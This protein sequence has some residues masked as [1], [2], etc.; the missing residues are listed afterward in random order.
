[1]FDFESQ[2]APQ[3]PFLPPQ[4]PFCRVSNS[5]C[6]V[7]EPPAAVWPDETAKSLANSL[8]RRGE[9]ASPF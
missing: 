2:T 9:S 8:L 3:R 6:S 7:A 1:M 5:L 4:R